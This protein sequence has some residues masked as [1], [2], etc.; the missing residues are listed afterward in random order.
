MK[1]SPLTSKSIPHSKGDDM[2]KLIWITT[3]LLIALCAFVSCAQEP[4]SSEPADNMTDSYRNARQRVHDSSNIWLPQLEG[5]EIANIEVT[6]KAKPLVN[7]SFAGD[8]TLFNQL[9]TYLNETIGKEP[10]MSEETLKWW[11]IQYTENGQ[12]YVGNI[13]IDLYQGMIS[14]ASHFFRGFTVT[15][16]AKPAAGGTA[17]IYPGG[18]NKGV[19]SLT[20][21][22]N[23][24]T[25]LKAT[26][27][28]GYVFDYHNYLDLSDRA[29]YDRF[30]KNIE[31]RNEIVTSVDVKYGD[32]FLTL[33][34]CS[35]EF[36]PS[37]F[38][39]FARRTRKGESTDVDTSGAHIN[40]DAKEP[41][42]K[43]IFR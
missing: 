27:A 31:Q 20:E 40:S 41:D 13:S 23:S 18:S 43:V 15:I 29:V 35:N 34:T 32:E 6:E 26:P 17:L 12:V 11:E 24:D 25:D 1:Q 37:R 2:K 3:I 21:A 38:V 42:W 4:S 5:V 39:I 28:D 16:T 33:S 10:D 14:L 36:E 19:S 9:A 8:A 22:E 7:I 30:M